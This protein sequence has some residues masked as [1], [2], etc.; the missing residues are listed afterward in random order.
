MGDEMGKQ[1]RDQINEMVRRIE[2]QQKKPPPL[3]ELHLKLTYEEAI[4][5]ITT[6][7][8]LRGDKTFEEPEK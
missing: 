2:E 3:I 5:I 7:A 1:M 8:R 6:L 4:A